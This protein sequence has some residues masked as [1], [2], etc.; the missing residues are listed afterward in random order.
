MNTK[1]H[2]I[3]SHHAGQSATSITLY[4]LMVQKDKLWDSLKMVWNRICF[5]QASI[6]VKPAWR[7]NWQPINGCMVLADLHLRRSRLLPLNTDGHK[8]Y[9]MEKAI[10]HQTW[11]IRTWRRVLWTDEYKFNL[12]RGDGRSSVLR[13]RDEAIHPNSVLPCVQA[14]DA[15]LMENTG[16]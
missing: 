13:S 5:N 1:W 4:N 6:R 2:V 7:V 15:S 3:I 11:N 14:R 12:V 9:T 10:H 16:W 8:R